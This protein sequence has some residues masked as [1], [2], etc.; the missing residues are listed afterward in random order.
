MSFFYVE[1]TLFS[2]SLT[3][4]YSNGFWSREHSLCQQARILPP[5]LYSS[6]RK[7]YPFPLNHALLTLV[8]F[9][10]TACITT[11]QV[12]YWIVCEP[13]SPTR[14]WS[15]LGWKPYLIIFAQVIF[16]LLLFS[17]FK[18]LSNTY[19]ALGTVFEFLGMTKTMASLQDITD[20]GQTK[21]MC[22]PYCYD[23]VR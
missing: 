2:S 9:I 15:F 11:W 10:S 22:I 12:L 21:Q 17:P 1:I 19:Y 5:Q 23:V 8:F 6:S 16:F 14:L 3:R 13:T 20:W 7:S 4:L 18:H